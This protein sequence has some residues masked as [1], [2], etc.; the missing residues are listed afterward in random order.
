MKTILVVEDIELNRDLLVQILEDDFVVITA[1]DGGAGI[2]R[3][4]EERPDVILM[5]L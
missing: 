1:E 3:A 5:D 4:A 2:A